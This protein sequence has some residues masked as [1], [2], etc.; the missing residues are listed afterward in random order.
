MKRFWI[1]LIC[2]SVLL[3]PGCGKQRADAIDDAVLDAWEG[4]YSKEARRDAVEQYAMKYIPVYA[5]NMEGTTVSFT[6]DY[7]AV[8]CGRVMLAPVVTNGKQSE[9][10]TVVDF[11]TQATLDGRT[12]IVD[13]GWWNNASV[14][15]KSYQIWGYLLW[16]KD[17]DDVMHYYYF[18]VDHT[19]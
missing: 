19:V 3:F 12:V 15:T 2:L 13:I 5:V 1:L 10:D 6:V 16:V 18:R 9:V 7:D 17:A 8:S 4:A 14:V 11:D